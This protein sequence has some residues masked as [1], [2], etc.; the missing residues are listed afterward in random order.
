MKKFF[1]AI[2]AAIS[3]VLFSACE[4]EPVKVCPV[5]DVVIETPASIGDYLVVSGNG[6]KA[7]SKL[8]VKAADQSLTALEDLEL[9]GTGMRGLLPKTLTTGT[10]ALILDQE[11]TWDLGNVLLQDAQN[12]LSNVTAPAVIKIGEPFTLTGVGF[13]EGLSFYLVS[14]SGRY[15][16]SVQPTSEGAQ[17][18]CPADLPAGEYSIL[19]VSALNEWTVC[20]HI[21]AAVYKRLSSFELTESMNFSYD[22]AAGAEILAAMEI[23]EEMIDMYLDFYESLAAQM[24]SASTQKT[25]LVLNSAGQVEKISRT[26]TVGGESSSSDVCLFEYSGST[27]TGTLPGDSGLVKFVWTLDADGRVASSDA[28][29]RKSSGDKTYTYD[30]HYG[31]DR[32]LAKIMY[33]STDYDV[34]TYEGGNLTAVKSPYDQFADL[35]SY[36]DQKVNVFSADAVRFLCMSLGDMVFDV[37]TQLADMLGLIGPA[38]QNTPKTFGYYGASNSLDCSVDADGYITSVSY[39]VEGAPS[40]EIP[41]AIENSSTSIRFIYE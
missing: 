14:A 18:Q 37:D 10:Y 8:S 29:Y 21:Q 20:E 36:S 28:T 5:T 22:R 30:Y 23:P 9:T 19:V 40:G 13:S 34:M 7:D 11:G 17:A 39:S 1:L 32:R 31:D 33:G 4:P 16:L 12:P 35:A 38:S 24:S 26:V 2:A 27:V 3:A 6:F 41:G 25:E 15:P